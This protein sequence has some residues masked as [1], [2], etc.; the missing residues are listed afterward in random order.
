MTKRNNCKFCG[1]YSGKS[2]TCKN[3]KEKYPYKPSKKG[4]P[5]NRQEEYD[6]EQRRKKKEKFQ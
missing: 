6:K 3:C 5:F 4:K 1:E 2:D